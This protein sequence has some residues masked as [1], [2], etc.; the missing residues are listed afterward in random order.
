MKANTH[1]PTDGVVSNSNTWAVFCSG[2]MCVT[3]TSTVSSIEEPLTDPFVLDGTKV[4]VKQ[5]QWQYT[6]VGTIKK[7]LAF[8]FEVSSQGITLQARG[9]GQCYNQCL[10]QFTCQQLHQLFTLIEQICTMNLQ[11]WVL[12][13]WSFQYFMVGLGCHKVARLPLM[14]MESGHID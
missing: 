7:T 5:E 2:D 9:F 10:E 1:F 6:D 3:S 4:S 13:F 11:Q 8:F 12:Q 14:I